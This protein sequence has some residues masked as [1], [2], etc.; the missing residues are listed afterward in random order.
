MGTDRTDKWKPPPHGPRW[1]A[2]GEARTHRQRFGHQAGQRDLLLPPKPIPNAWDGDDPLELARS[3]MSRARSLREDPHAWPLLVEPWAM[4]DE[5]KEELEFE[6][7]GPEDLPD[8]LGVPWRGVDGKRL[9]E[10][11]RYE[12]ARD[13]VDLA[14]E[15]SGVHSTGWKYTSPS[16]GFRP[17]ETGIYETMPPW[18]A[19]ALV[20][21]ALTH[22]RK[23]RIKLISRDEAR[24]FIEKHHTHMPWIHDN[25]WIYSIGMFQGTRLAAVA[26]G[27]TVGGG[28]AVGGP[29]SKR[30][31]RQ[32][33]VYCNYDEVAP[34]AEVERVSLDPRNILELTRVA[35][36]GTIKGASSMLAARIL[37]LAP[38]TRRGDPDGPWLFV[39]YS[40]ATEDGSTYKALR[41]LGLRPVHQRTLRRAK[42]GARGGAE[43]RAHDDVP[44]IRWEAGPAAME[45][46]W[47][48]VEPT[49]GQQR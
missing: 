5:D 48:L 21:D 45:A 10:S 36:D 23:S 17:I 49:P 4:S 47:S 33:P 18:L 29:K 3:L 22:D 6:V 32:V 16:G 27:H 12:L 41:E 25:G 9:S 8:V 39:T 31:A 19:E 42:T 38:A 37:K 13:L 15:E 20:Y 43:R 14:R 26:T 35:S 46:D 34:E 11:A 44:K 7:W 30:P 24:A 40:L 2:V 1:T 28:W